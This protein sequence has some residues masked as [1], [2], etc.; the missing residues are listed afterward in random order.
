MIKK[1]KDIDDALAEAPG[2]LREFLLTGDGVEQLMREVSDAFQNWRGCPAKSCR[3][4]RSCQ[5]P[6]MMCQ[7]R[8]PRRLNAPPEEIA[9]ANARMRQLVERRL[10][11]FGIVQW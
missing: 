3:R 11:R 1:M 10:E 9:H 6:D 5:G 7:L 2:D 8:E 4:A